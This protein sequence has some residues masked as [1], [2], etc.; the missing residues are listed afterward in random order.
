MVSFVLFCFLSFA[1]TSLSFIQFS[2]DGGCISKTR[3]QNIRKWQ[4]SGIINPLLDG[5][6]YNRFGHFA[7]CSHFSS[8]LRGLENNYATHKISTRIAYS[9]HIIPEC[10]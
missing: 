7:H 8:P 3:K 4:N 10:I 6:T 2:V 5:L 1:C 9:F